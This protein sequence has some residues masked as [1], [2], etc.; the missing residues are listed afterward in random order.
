MNVLLAK[1]SKCVGHITYNILTSTQAVRGKKDR[2][3]TSGDVMSKR[4]KQ[5]CRIGSL[6]L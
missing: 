2:V 5:A 6:Q 1:Q 3:E 4:E